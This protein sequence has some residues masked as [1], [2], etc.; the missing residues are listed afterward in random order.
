M[1]GVQDTKPLLKNC[2]KSQ[3]K[4]KANGLKENSNHMILPIKAEKVIGQI[5][6]LYIIT[7]FI[8]ENWNEREPPSNVA[9]K[10][11]R[12]QCSVTYGWMTAVFK[13]GWFFV[14]CSMGW[15]HSLTFVCGWAGRE[16]PRSLCWC[17]RVPPH[18][19]CLS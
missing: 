19:L 11:T 10:H 16:G 8:V 12:H 1:K 4:C 2:K 13:A 14:P 17:G 9:A 5:Q 18:G 7:N 3:S 15:G 6:L